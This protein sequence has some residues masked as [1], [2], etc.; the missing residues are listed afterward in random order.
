MPEKPPIVLRGVSTWRWILRY[1]HDPLECFTEVQRRYGALAAIGSPLPLYTG[2]RRFVLAL[3]ERYNR[4]VLGQ[5]ELFRPGG[6]VLVGPR[7][8]AQFQTS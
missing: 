8:S 4:Q 1:L 2:G 3:G 5:P 6:Q 7:N